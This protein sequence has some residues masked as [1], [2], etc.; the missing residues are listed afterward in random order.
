MDSSHRPLSASQ[1]SLPDDSRPAEGEASQ[2]GPSRLKPGAQLT[3]M[4][5]LQDLPDAEV[6]PT[7]PVP[8]RYHTGRLPN[9]KAGDGKPRLLLMG[10]R[11]CASLPCGSLVG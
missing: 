4:R 1:H 10:Q 3:L 6:P 5:Y 9:S 11:R 2:A 7:D 8:P